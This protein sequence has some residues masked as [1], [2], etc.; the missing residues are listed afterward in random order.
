MESQANRT[1]HLVEVLDIF[2]DSV[3]QSTANGQQLSALA[4]NV[5]ALTTNGQQ[6]MSTTLSQMNTIDDIVHDAVKKV[7]SL[8]EQ[9]K[10]IT[11]LVS[12]I[13]DIANQTNLLA[14]NAAIEA[15]RAGEHGKGFAVVADEVRKLAEQVKYSVSDITSIVE[16]IQDETNIVTTSLHAG[17]EEVKKG[18]A[19]MTTTNATFDN[20]F[21]AVVA[22]RTNIRDISSNLTTIDERTETINAIVGD[23]AA[24]TEQSTA[25]VQQTSASVQET[26]ST[27]EEVAASTAQL[28]Q[29]VEELNGQVS[30]FKLP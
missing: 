30:Q 24:V 13:S 8:N 27:M 22:M 18:T 1:T 4:N 14:L 7:E 5:E 3:T 6:L 28:A 19:E 16:V 25:G 17:Y 2:K 21:D 29:M 23:I 15:A 10:E 11:N 26:S 12:V 9:S 20:I